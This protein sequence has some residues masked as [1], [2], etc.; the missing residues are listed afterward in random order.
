MKIIFLAL[1]SLLLVGCS[2]SITNENVVK[3]NSTEIEKTDI[4]GTEDQSTYKEQLED[5]DVEKN[6][7]EDDTAEHNI[8]ED[9]TKE[10]N[11]T[12]EN[13]TEIDT[14]I[15]GSEIHLDKFSG[16]I[17]Y[18]SEGKLM[19][20]SDDV[21]LMDMN[22]LEI[23][24][25]SD[26]L[27]KGVSLYDFWDY[28]IL[29][30]TDGYIIYGNLNNKEDGTLYLTMLKM[31]KE[32]KIQS[33]VNVSKLLN[34]DN[35]INSY[36]L[37]ENGNK[38]IYSMMDGFY[39]YDFEADI[40][41]TLFENEVSVTDCDIRAG[42]N[43]IF[44]TGEDTGNQQI[45]GIM[46]LNSKNLSLREEKHLWGNLWCFDDYILVQEADVYGKENEQVVFCLKPTGNLQ[47]YPLS[48]KKENMNIIPSNEGNYYA[49]RT[50]IKGEGFFV[51]IYASENGK[52]IR[53]IPMLFSEYGEKFRLSNLLICEKEKKIILS[54][55]GWKNGG[56]GIWIVSMDF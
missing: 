3:N 15:S 55:S 19:I 1:L 17:A 42:S 21:K 44:F 10:E 4:L 35:S 33:I 12:E 54:V 48:D 14:S 13:A 11:V 23:L 7:T 16:S 56:D 27:D 43:V 29:P 22:T 9:N 46:D 30:C 38:L 52:L 45:F 47:V 24:A 49:T 51:R 25:E 39:L 34:L 40:I 2:T 41:Q 32:M 8:T 37:F 26:N 18:A 53:E 20:I 31:N 36:K 5:S 50:R 28:D 6:V